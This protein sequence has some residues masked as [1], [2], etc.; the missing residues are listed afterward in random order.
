VERRKQGC[1]ET[2]LHRNMRIPSGATAASVSIRKTR[3][4]ER[5]REGAINSGKIP[6][7][8]YTYRW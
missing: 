2:V 5:E 1:S 3:Q 8:I 6:V 7:Y 4:R